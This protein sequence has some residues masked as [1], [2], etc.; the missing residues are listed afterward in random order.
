[1]GN[2]TRPERISSQKLFKL[3]LKPEVPRW[4]LLDPVVGF[5]SAR[6]LN[7]TGWTGNLEDLYIFHLLHGDSEVNR[8]HTAYGWNAASGFS[9]GADDAR[10]LMDIFYGQADE[11]IYRE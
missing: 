10:A 8:G 6:V 3:Y 4:A 5:A 11:R 7:T 2:F 1:M 9:G